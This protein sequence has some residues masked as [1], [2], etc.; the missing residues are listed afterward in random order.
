MNE[1]EEVKAR[2][3]IAEVVGSYVQLTKAGRTF[4]APC[5]FHS[6]KTPSFVIDPGRQSWHCFGAC[7]TGGDVISFVMKREGMD[8]PDALRLLADRAGVKLPERHASAEQDRTR[9]RIF[10][11]NEAAS[12]Y[13]QSLLKT[14]AGKI[15]ARYLDKRGLDEE[16]QRKFALGYSLGSWEDT[17]EHLKSKGFT[18]REML[19]AGLVLQGDNGL[20]D[21]FRGRLM[22]AVWDAKGRI[23]GFG[24]R[25]L[26]DSM[27]KYLNTAQTALFDKGGTLY[28]LD[29]AAEGIRREGL[30]V[31]V[32]G[33][34]DVIA[35]HQF[36]FDNVVAQMGTALTE[37]Q[38]KLLK[39]LSSQIVLALDADAAGMQAA[40]RGH[41]VVR[42]TAGEPTE[43]NWQGLLRHQES[44]A[45][46]LRVAVLP[47]GRDPD[48]VVRADPEKWREIIAGAEPVLDFRLGRAAAAHDL[49]SPRERSELVREFLPLLGA[50][51][52]AVVRSHY[53]QRLA[54]LAQTGEEEV[55]A[56]L[57]GT[58]ERKR[59]ESRTTPNLARRDI[60]TNPREDFLL[61]LLLQFPGLHELGITI[62]EDLLWEAQSKQVLEAWKQHKERDSVKEAVPVELKSYVERLIL[63]SVPVSTHEDAAEALQDC[64]SKLHQRQLQAEKQ[65]IAAQI[66]DLQDRIRPAGADGGETDAPLSMDEQLQELLVRDME[67]GRQL[68]SRGRKDGLSPVEIAVDG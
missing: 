29:K 16:T 19:N 23:I 31:V 25:A 6:E 60:V 61:A 7:G 28:A 21:R 42:E 12:G 49:T 27:P 2:L 68:H 30:A 67:I 32:E 57:R 39:R 51:N 5:P 41:D 50:V 34:M 43:L 33:Y 55:T 20:H 45:V 38:V 13:F 3:D 63:W 26:D 44:A 40:V 24:A 18:D 64:I 35:A 4:K 17:R 65:A 8:F 10:A 59:P 48:D 14:D 15:A 11:A 36:G 56:M 52:D 37:R 54:R 47:E 62:P 1:V 46:D 66:A 9:D 22:F 58:G 53:I